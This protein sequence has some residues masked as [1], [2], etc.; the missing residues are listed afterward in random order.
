MGK[1]NLMLK[2]YRNG[3]KVSTVRSYRKLS[4]IGKLR[5]VSG[6]KYYLRIGYGNEHNDGDYTTK[7]ELLKAYT[8][9]TEADLVRSFNNET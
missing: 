5:H 1:L 7:K 3:K 8:D 4:F 6:D 9:F 2:V